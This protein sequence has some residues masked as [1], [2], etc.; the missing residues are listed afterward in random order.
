MK[1]QT[2]FFLAFFA[3]FCSFVFLQKT[4]LIAQ[5]DD[6]TQRLEALE[7]QIHQIAQKR[8]E[9]RESLNRCERFASTATEWFSQLTR[10]EN[11]LSLLEQQKKSGNFNIYDNRQLD[12]QITDLIRERDSI[13][14]LHGGQVIEGSIYN[15][16]SEIE[17]E[18]KQ[19]SREALSLNQ[20]YADLSQQLRT[21][22]QQRDLILPQA[23]D[24][25][26]F[27]LTI[28]KSRL[29]YMQ[30][31][32]EL[33]QQLVANNEAWLLK[34]PFGTGPSIPHLSRKMVLI[35]LTNEYL[36]KIRTTPGKKFSQQELAQILKDFQ[37]D[38]EDLKNVL[39]NQIIPEYIATIDKLR[40]SISRSN[41][42]TPGIS[43]QWMVMVGNDNFPMIQISSSDEKVFSAVITRVGQ[44]DFFK[45]GDQLFTV[46][47]VNDET[48]D[49]T[50]H[51]FT[52]DGRKAKIPLRLIASR[53]G[54]SISYRADSLLT[55]RRCD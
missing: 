50:E 3:I 19:M 35:T 25:E 26:Q 37:K 8:L 13:K 5:P 52:A 22:D 11:Q 31:D 9:T 14:R 21:L 23:R 32:L 55:L 41:S 49:G 30:E 36:H 28:N 12:D 10:I 42:T 6:A 15:S 17:N 48:Y 46:T 20:Q 43:G 2:R 1:K 18:V 4:L 34:L 33:M 7:N 53:D 24:E 51:S 54:K 39:R 47:R 45:P 27:R 16:L 29:Q 38:S 44:L 40:L